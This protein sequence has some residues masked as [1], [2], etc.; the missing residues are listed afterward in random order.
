MFSSLFGDDE[1]NN[2]S[3]YSVVIKQ[4]RPVR[5]PT[6]R[7]PVFPCGL[8]SAGSTCYLNSVLQLLFHVIPLRRGILDIEEPIFEDI[9]IVK[10]TNALRIL[11]SELNCIDKSFTSPEL[12]FD[13]FS[14]SGESL[15][16]QHDAQEFLR[17]LLDG[18]NT[19]L[20][21]LPH[22]S[23]YNSLCSNITSLF[24]GTFVRSITCNS[25]GSL[26]NTNEPFMDVILP[27]VG[28]STLENLIEN[29]QETEFL[30]GYTCDS[31]GQ[32]NTSSKS[33]K[34][35]SLPPFLTLVLSRFSYDWNKDRRVKT[36]AKVAFPCSFSLH[37][38]TYNL[39]GFIEH[40]GSAY[41]GH[42]RTVLNF[43][44]DATI[45]CSDA[46][47]DPI[48][49]DFSKYFGGKD[50]AY[51]L[52][53]V[54]STVDCYTDFSAAKM[55]DPLPFDL[56]NLVKEQNQ[57]L[58]EAREAYEKLIDVVIFDIH[59][60]FVGRKVCVSRD[61]SLGQA[62]ELAGLTIPQ[63]SCLWNITEPTLSNGLYHFE[64]NEFYPDFLDVND[65]FSDIGIL[66]DCF[67]IIAGLG[68]FDEEAEEMEG[69]TVVIKDETGITITL[70]NP[71]DFAG[72]PQ[73]FLIDETN[74]LRSINQIIS[75]IRCQYNLTPDIPLRLRVADE[76]DLAQEVASNPSS[77]KNFHA[78][79]G[80]KFFLERN[81]FVPAHYIV[82]HCSTFHFGT[83]DALNPLY[84]VDED[85]LDM[86][87]IVSS[88]E[89]SFVTTTN[90]S[91]H[92]KFPHSYSYAD[93]I[94][95]FSP[96]ESIDID[97][98]CSICDLSRHFFPK[99]SN[100]LVILFDKNEVPIAVF[101]AFSTASLK[102]SKITS[103]CHVS[104]FKTPLSVPPFSISL[105]PVFL[106][107]YTPVGTDFVEEPQLDN[108][109]LL[110]YSKT[111]QND[112]LLSTI[113]SFYNICPENTSILVY[114]KKGGSWKPLP[115]TFSKSK[116]RGFKAGDILLVA[117]AD[118]PRLSVL[119]VVT[120]KKKGVNTKQ[121]KQRPVEHTLNLHLS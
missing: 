89:K 66:E 84:I 86:C 63:G 101:P 93:T 17:L 60:D 6:H 62:V 33:I 25:C 113:S 37:N 119:S 88:D 2:S 82:V 95:N 57:K 115:P 80:E 41:G 51:I 47:V 19:N 31:C 75:F 109:M 79:S 1:D 87:E 10:L 102:S 97:P 23:H 118:D 100:L 12:L 69:E 83:L 13:V 42:Y 24:Q 22:L 49:S 48:K 27:V 116:V 64:R 54:A 52:L 70:L 46:V 50:C 68:Y 117:L 99:T 90:Y 18:F 72:I 65:V 111:S 8:E 77:T 106:T 78:F 3:S 120:K 85:D 43:S 71:E 35:D 92:Y 7:N 53:Y 32:C 98:N 121:V 73:T 36:T 59:Q 114:P 96:L 55:F 76:W 105:V 104:F 38:I 26:K 107:F 20:T 112:E 5:P 9:P 44:N 81:H 16:V 34:F 103:S 30:D 45:L 28:P 67:L 21:H 74:N 40:S 58:T 94:I 29:I 110:L 15:R 11:F 108:F 4:G 61:L 91:A 56:S 39:I 14:W